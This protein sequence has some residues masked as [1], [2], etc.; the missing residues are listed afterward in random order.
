MRNLLMVLSVFGL[1]ACS[2][3]PKTGHQETDAVIAHMSKPKAVIG[4]DWEEKFKRDGLI[5]GEFVAIGSTVSHINNHEGNMRLTAEADATSRLLTSAPTEFKKIVQR[6]VSSVDGNNGTTDQVH[7]SITEVKALT[8]LKTKFEDSQCVTSATPNT[9]LKYDFLKECR[10][11][12]RVPA[13]NLAKAYS[14]TLDKK[15]GIKE[16]SEIKEAL[17]KHLLSEIKSNPE[18]EVASSKEAPV[19]KA[20]EN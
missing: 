15:Y 10:T 20:S 17:N 5:G 2:S 6:A 13:S 12:M 18:R 14:Y 8:G 19:A 16:Q 1:A 11:I 3:V 7:I 4:K 9:D